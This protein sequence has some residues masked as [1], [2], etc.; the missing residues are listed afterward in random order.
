MIDAAD[1]DRD[2]SRTGVA[3][4][5][6]LGIGALLFGV[7]FSV[8]LSTRIAAPVR[9]L[10]VAARKV[11]AGEYDASVPTGPP[12]ELGRLASAFNDM[13]TGL[14]TYRALESERAV[15]SQRRSAAVIEAIDDGV[16]VVD[17]RLTVIDLNPAAAT[18]LGTTTPH[19]RGRPLGDLAADAPFLAATS[20]AAEGRAAESR[21]AGY[22]AAAG[23]EY[24][25]VVT[26]MTGPSGASL[27]A[28][29]LF[30]DVTQLRQLDRLKGE[31]VATAS[32]EL[33]TPVTSLGMSVG[34]LQERLAGRLDDSERGLLNAATE[35]VDRL[36]A[37]ADDLLDLSRVE[38]GRLDLEPVPVEPSSIVE[39]A[40]S[41]FSVAAEGA[42]LSV[43]A[44]S[45]AGLPSVI[46]DAP[47]IRRVLANLMA[48]AIRHT[49]AG[50]HVAVR[51]S[52][53]DDG[54]LF[55]VEDTGEGIAQEDQQRVFD[56]FVRVAGSRAAGGTGLGLT[57][58][59][60]IVEAHGGRIGVR[61]ERGR[62]STFWFVLPVEAES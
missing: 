60:E 46:V 14:R 39:E 27:G 32:H 17:Q 16:V 62:G 13:A 19:A 38:A 18:A 11:A 29:V 22:V 47:R 55:E 61:S 34:L 25:V 7:A 52:S 35:D 42:G 41:A 37:L 43:A 6:V 26:P 31:F 24:E 45:Q 12:D 15:Q 23:R 10:E 21:E 49:P 48:N 44:S 56:R 51:A 8:L 58:A 20:D 57:L 59:R 9:R 53:A 54:V 5:A 3:A 28:V 33:R 30:R 1:R 2:A 36:R 40:A 50:G 4:L